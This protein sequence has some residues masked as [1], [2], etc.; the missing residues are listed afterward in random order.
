MTP[1]WTARLARVLR[2]LGVQTWL[3][4]IRVACLFGVAI[5]LGIAS[6]HAVTIPGYAKAN[7]GC[8][9]FVI[10]MLLLWR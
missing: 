3:D 9:A 8:F 6:Y 2:F 7:A 5:C 1:I 4:L 10:L